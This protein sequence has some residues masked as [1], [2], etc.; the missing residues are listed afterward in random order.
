M[1]D[2]LTLKAARWKKLAA[3]GDATGQYNYGYCLQ[4]GEGVD[5]DLSE[6][7]RYYKMAADQGLAIA[8]NNYA[9]CL[10]EGEGVDKNLSEAAVYYKM[11][12]DQGF[13]AGQYNYASC[14]EKG[15]G[16][17]KNLSEA[18]R[19]YKMAADQGVANAQN[20]Y[21]SCLKNGEGV[22]KNLSEAAR[23]YKM[24][25]DQGLAAGQY[26]YGYCLQYGEGVDR[27]LSEAARYF[28]MSADQGVAAGQYEYGLCVKNGEG[29]AKNLPEAVR[30]FKMSADQGDERGA[31]Q[32]RLCM[33][34]LSTAH[35][36][37]QTTTTIADGVMDLNDF[38]KVRELGRGR[39]GVVWLMKN[40][41]TNEHLAVK[42]IGI[43]ATF[44]SDRLLREIG[45]LTLL[46]HPCIVRIIGYSLPTSECK[47]ARIVTEF[48]SN[49]SLEDALTR[50]NGRE[51]PDFWTH[52]NIT[53]MMIG[54]VLGMKYLHSES[55]IHRDLK[56]GNILVD[57]KGE[58]RIADFGT[59]KLETC[60]TTTTGVVGTLGY[61][62][63][64]TL[65]G[66]EAT[67]KSDVFAFGLILFEVLVETSVFPKGGSIVQLVE[68][69][70]QNT[71]PAIPD[72]I[73]PSIAK[74]I[75]KCWST[76]PEDR[77]TFEEIFE[78]LAKN[79][80]PFFRDVEY[81]ECERFICEV[82]AKES[83]KGK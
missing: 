2:S 62:A 3:E 71:R 56:P 61:M 17:S 63:Y 41:N 68:M 57:E 44:E 81:S 37:S 55:I 15:S 77:P 59:A 67:R 75:R 29:V 69:H 6:A 4:Y 74:I 28:K 25:A 19:Y 14:L 30:Y 64:E 31:E 8:Q 65:K 45:V 58:I 22:D 48:M 70:M 27:D 82:L 50:V 49:G 33:E 60:G 32:Y 11:A 40:K 43:G 34:L 54:L 20:N 36:A 18:V 7:A 46:T 16:V 1:S 9:F 72:G 24:A 38:E 21:A 51:I 13:A 35:R 26:N 39:F 78:V 73:H 80:F 52:N 83:E 10:Q 12:A 66:G 47:K 53:K 42:Y 76:N 5:R 23:Y 79:W